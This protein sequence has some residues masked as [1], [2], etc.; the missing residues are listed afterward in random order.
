[1]RDIPRQQGED[2]YRIFIRALERSFYGK[3]IE[4][5]PDKRGLK[6]AG[7]IEGG[8]STGKQV[9]YHS[10]LCNP[11]DRTFNDIEFMR[12]VE[13]CWMKTPRAMKNTAISVQIEKIYDL[14]GWTEYMTKHGTKTS[15]PGSS[16]LDMLDLKTLK[17]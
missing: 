6:H 7:I 12:R 10:I 13:S 14:A 3:S 8:G 15:D 11:E 9:H 16:Y 4:R 5:H 2:Q 1:M 17:L